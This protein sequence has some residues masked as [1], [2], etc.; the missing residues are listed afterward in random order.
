ME[1][2]G[3]PWVFLAASTALVTLVSYVWA[4]VDKNQDQP[5]KIAFRSAIVALFSLALV[6]WLGHGRGE[7]GPLTIPYAAE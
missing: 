6:T 7:G 5:G 2:L 3:D 4:A 1:S